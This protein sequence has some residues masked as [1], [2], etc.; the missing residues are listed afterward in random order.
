MSPDNPSPRVLIVEDHAIL[1]NTLASALEREG[2]DVESVS[3]PTDEIL[4]AVFSE[5]EPDAVLLDL[6]LGG[7][8]TSLPHI[9]SM[10]RTGSEVVVLTG[11]VDQRLHAEALE[12]G[13]A[14][15]VSKT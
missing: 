14:G 6:D 2:F 12:R 7:G 5:F 9:P 15:I 10:R 1:A 8:R 3:E 11:T 4:R 13:A